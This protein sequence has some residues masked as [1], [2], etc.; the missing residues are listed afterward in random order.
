MHGTTLPPSLQAA[1]TL[2][3]ATASHE[4]GH[5]FGMQHST[6]PNNEYGDGSCV[7]STCCNIR[8]KGGREGG[9]SLHPAIPALT[10][11]D[12]VMLPCQEAEVGV[13]PLLVK[14]LR[15]TRLPP[16]PPPACVPLQV[17]KR[18]AVVAAGLVQPH[19]GAE[20]RYFSP[21]NVV[22]LRAAGDRA[23]SNQPRAGE[24]EEE[25][26]STGKSPFF[27]CRGICTIS[28]LPQ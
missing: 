19:F 24:E 5:N 8:W 20:R 26:T 3:L 2:S 17:S 15:S 14:K 28:Q 13:T 11:Y 7:M 9:A 10:A 12:F 23:D 22:Q 1:Y 21:R 6:T 25:D 16:P 4:L 27:S 18:P